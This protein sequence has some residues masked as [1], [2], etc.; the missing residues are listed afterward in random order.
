MKLLIITQ[1]VDKKDSALGFFHGWLVEFAK[2]SEKLAVICLEEGEHN[3]PK[4]V[5]VFSL[6]K[7][8]QG[9]PALGWE[10]LFSKL[11]VLISFYKYIFKL[12]KEYDSVFVHMNKEYVILGGL[13]WKLWNK[14]VAL[15]YTHKHVDIKLRLAEKLVNIVFTASKESFRLKSSKVKVV[16]H[17]IDV[18]TFKPIEKKQSNVFRIVTVGRISPVK[19]YE[20][21]IGAT[22]ILIKKNNS[23]IQV[24]VIGGPSTAEDE[25]YLK[26]LHVLVQEK[27]LEQVIHFVGS[28]PNRDLSARLAHADVFVNMSRTGGLDKAVLEAMACGIPVVTSNESLT[29]VLGFD[30]AMLVFPSGDANTCASRIEGVYTLSS[31]SY[32]MLTARLHMTVEK[33]HNINMLIPRI[34]SVYESSR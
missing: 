2:Y 20:T 31:D 32:K 4:N 16:G 30:V 15:W 33:E 23:S 10:R 14:K 21:L 9:W 8:T 28:V 6:G 19:D 22:E 3:L 29:P 17:G 25:D 12:R 34:L 26:R 18:E 1:K 24:E 13:F 7:P 5:Q 11:K 27:H